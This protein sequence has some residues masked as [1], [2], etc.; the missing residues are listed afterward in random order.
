MTRVS[1]EGLLEKVVVSPY[2]SIATAMARLDQAGT[3]ALVVCSANRTLFGVLTDGDIRRALLRAQSLDSPCGSICSRQAVSA[4]DSNSSSEMLDAMNHHD[5]NHLP[6]V[7]GDGVVVDLILR[8]DLGTRIELDPMSLSRLRTAIFSPEA[9]IAEA[10]AALDRAGTGALVLCTEDGMLRGL[11]T[12]GDIRRAVLH[13][14][15]MDEACYGIASAQPL[16]RISLDHTFPGVANHERTRHQSPARRGWKQPLYWLAASQGPCT[17]HET[18]PVS[19]DHGRRIWETLAAADRTCSEA[20][21]ARRGSSSS[22]TD[23]ST[24]KALR[25][26]RSQSYDPLPIRF[27]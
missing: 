17:R 3:G 21:A 4:A 13:G 11:L 22:G 15:A 6:I 25:H 12:D 19:C 9:S 20:H 7:D 14:T 23:D 8:R 10:I 5:I 2:D 16:A 26:S 1:V 24:A 18:E 27:H